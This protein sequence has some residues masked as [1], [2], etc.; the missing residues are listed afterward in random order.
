MVNKKQEKDMTNQTAMG[1]EVHWRKM[2]IQ[3]ILFFFVFCAKHLV[4]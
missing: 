4:E 1:A 3:V 2:V